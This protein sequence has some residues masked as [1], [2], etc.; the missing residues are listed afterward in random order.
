M[1]VQWVDLL[2]RQLCNSELAGEWFLGHMSEEYW[3]PLEIFI[4]CPSQMVRQTFQRLCLQIISKL[5]P[6]H[7][8]LYLKTER[9]GPDSSCV[10]RFI[11]MLLNL[12][13]T[14]VSKIHTIKMK[15]HGIV[16]KSF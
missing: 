16:H 15:N 4:K 6:L 11:N 5:R 9:Q 8:P 7:A 1:L 13:C 2:S 12:V 10:T 3:W 14:V